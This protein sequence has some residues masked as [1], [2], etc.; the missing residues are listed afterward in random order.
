MSECSVGSVYGG[1]YESGAAAAVCCEA[2]A[3]EAVVVA[4]CGKDCVV[5]SE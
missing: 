5:V 1:G 3:V 4:V 2:G